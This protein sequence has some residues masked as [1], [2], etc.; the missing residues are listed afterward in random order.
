MS[1]D[2]TFEESETEEMA[3][4]KFKRQTVRKRF[5]ENI[6]KRNLSRKKLGTS[7]NSRNGYTKTHF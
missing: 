1:E 5:R 2:A 3:N 7:F 6:R 4:K